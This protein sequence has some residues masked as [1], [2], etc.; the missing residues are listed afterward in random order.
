LIL[1]ADGP[2]ISIRLEA[3]KTAMDL[4]D[5]EDQLYTARKVL[6]FVEELY[7]RD[8]ESMEGATMGSQDAN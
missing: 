5:I 4:L 6:G 1:T 2:A 3:I 8:K 7:R